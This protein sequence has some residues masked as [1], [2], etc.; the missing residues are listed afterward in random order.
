MLYRAIRQTIDSDMDTTLA[1]V[2][3]ISHSALRAFLGQQPWPL[4]AVDTPSFAPLLPLQPVAL[5]QLVRVLK[6]HYIF[7]DLYVFHAAS[8]EAQVAHIDWGAIPAV[9]AQALAAYVI[10]RAAGEPFLGL[11]GSLDTAQRGEI[12]LLIPASEDPHATNEAT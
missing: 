11:A 8:T 10:G 1:P 3:T 9:D 2:V 6:S 12:F 5:T 7:S 4:W